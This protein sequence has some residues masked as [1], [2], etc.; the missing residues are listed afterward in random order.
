MDQYGNL[1]SAHMA[2]KL[3][4]RPLTNKNDRSDNFR[5]NSNSNHRKLKPA[6][7]SSFG[8]LGTRNKLWVASLNDIGD[9]QVSQPALSN[10]NSIL[11]Q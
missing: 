2:N 11:N 5:N 4:S 1:E 3:M 9:H 7:E 8:Q 6:A 10:F